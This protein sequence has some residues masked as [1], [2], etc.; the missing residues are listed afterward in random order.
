MVESGPSVF[1]VNCLGVF[2]TVD[3]AIERFRARKAGHIAIM[4]SI[5]SYMPGGD[6]T[7]VHYM[8]SKAAMRSYVRHHQ[9]SPLD[10]SAQGPSVLRP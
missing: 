4:A 8:A 5:A 6:P 7:W 2:H 10:R 3:P 1:D 9:P